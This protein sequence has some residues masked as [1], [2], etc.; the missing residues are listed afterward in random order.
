MKCV[1]CKHG[2]TKSGLATLTRTREGTVLV[3]KDVPADVCS[4]CGE[5]YIA[6]EVGRRV[7]ELLGEMAN[8]GVEL[9]VRRYEAA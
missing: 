1:I 3:I 2:E 5:E 8:R 4:T 9:E 6:E 7:F